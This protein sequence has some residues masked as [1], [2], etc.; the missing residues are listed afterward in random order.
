MASGRIRNSSQEASRSPSAGIVLAGSA[1]AVAAPVAERLRDQLQV[2]VVRE[3]RPALAHRDVMR[4]IEAERADITEGSDH[5]TVIGRA[6]GVATVFDQPQAVLLAQGRHH[7]QVVRVAQRMR[8]HDGLG[9]RGDRGLQ[10]AGVHVVGAEFHIHKHG[11]CAKLQN[12]VDR[13][14]KA[15][16][17]AN[18]FIAPSDSPF[19]QFR[20][21]ERGKRHQIGRGTG[22]DGDQVLYAQILGQALFEGVIEAARR[23]PT[24]QR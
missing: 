16:G 20:R 7:V 4:G 12:R 22:V 10:Q 23:Q 21:S 19:A 18:H 14:G 8:Q 9:A 17:H 3:D 2:R 24:V 11:Y 1:V 13:G 5:A 6:Q 15:R